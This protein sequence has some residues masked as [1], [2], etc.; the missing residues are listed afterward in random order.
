MNN[1]THTHTL[2]YWGWVGLQVTLVMWARFELVPQSCQVIEMP[3][4]APAAIAS[5]AMAAKM[6]C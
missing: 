4:W 6:I 3:A 5:S 1:N 2:A